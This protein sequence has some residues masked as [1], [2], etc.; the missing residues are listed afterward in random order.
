MPQLYMP[1]AVPRNSVGKISA[2]IDATKGVQPASL[3]MVTG[4]N[5]KDK[6]QTLPKIWI[7]ATAPYLA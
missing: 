6:H 2:I 7:H 5:F 1:R 4:I 3:K